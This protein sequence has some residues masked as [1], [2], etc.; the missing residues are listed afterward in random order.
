MADG[1]DCA[2][3][4]PLVFTMLVKKKIAELVKNIMF[5]KLLCDKSSPIIPS[6]NRTTEAIMFN[7]SFGVAFMIVIIFFMSIVNTSGSGLAQS[8]PSAKKLQTVYPFYIQIPLYIIA[9]L[10]ISIHRLYIVS[11]PLPNLS[12]QESY[13][14]HGT[15]ILAFSV[16]CINFML[17]EILFSKR[18]LLSIIFMVIIFIPTIIFTSMLDEFFKINMKSSIAIGFLIMIAG[19]LLSTLVANLLYKYPVS[20]HVMKENNKA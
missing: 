13:A 2:S 20:A 17:Y 12:L 9:F 14:K 18:T 6:R 4:D 8:S 3:P 7:F 5:D 10:L 11:K 16:L 1:D 15:L 19:S